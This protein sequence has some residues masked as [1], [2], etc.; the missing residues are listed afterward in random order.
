LTGILAA[1]H[2]NILHVGIHRLGPYT[3]LGR[4]GLDVIVDTRDRAHSEEVLALVKSKGF[5]AEEVLQTAPPESSKNV[6]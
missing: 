5:P 6:R 2:I 1:E 4:V 3:A